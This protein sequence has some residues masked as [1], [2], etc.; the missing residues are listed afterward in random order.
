MKLNAIELRDEHEGM[1]IECNIMMIGANAST[2][3]K[4]GVSEGDRVDIVGTLRYSHA[5]Q[6]LARAVRV[7][8]IAVESVDGVKIDD[9]TTYVI[10]SNMGS[11]IT[12]DLTDPMDVECE[13]EN[14]MADDMMAMFGQPDPD[15]DGPVCGVGSCAKIAT[16]V[17]LDIDG[18]TK[19]PVCE[20]DSYNTRFWG[21]WPIGE[22]S[23]FGEAVGG[24]DDG[25]PV[26]SNKAQP[27]WTRRVESSIRYAE[28]NIGRRWNG[29]AHLFA[30]VDEVGRLIRR[31]VERANRD[32][33]REISRLVSDEG[34]PF[35]DASELRR[36]ADQRATG[37]TL[38]K[39]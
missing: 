3:Y 22:D 39:V 8:T 6:S 10:Q 24:G 15:S 27:D 36:M 28:I 7:V 11:H 37:V 18:E 34:L 21:V 25:V 31:R 9:P 2:L 35:E 13:D 32:E 26:G 5:A 19:I 30:V 16:H 23:Q 20:I 4:W 12:V 29:R 33:H 38:A 17:G 1:R 14:L